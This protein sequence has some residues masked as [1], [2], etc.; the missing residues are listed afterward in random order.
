MLFFASI[1]RYPREKTGKGQRK[2]KP[3]LTARKSEDKRSV[4][5]VKFFCQNT[6]LPMGG[7]EIVTNCNS[8]S[9]RRRAKLEIV[10][11]PYKQIL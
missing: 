11:A 3:P 4:E 9:D 6:I 5:T 2:C 8:M 7:V 1:C 10:A